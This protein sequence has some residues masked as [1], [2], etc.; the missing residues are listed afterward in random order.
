MEIMH[1]GIDN[2][3]EYKKFIKRNNKRSFLDILNV[4]TFQ[5]ESKQVYLYVNKKVFNRYKIIAYAIIE[6]Q[7]DNQLYMDIFRYNEKYVNGNYI[8]I[9]DFYVHDL[10]RRRGIGTL[11]ASEIINIFYC[12][13][14]IILSPDGDGFN[15]WNKLGFE[16]DNISEKETWVKDGKKNGKC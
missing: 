4:I 7:L 1:F 9:S 6:E 14:G 15:F 8:Y 11:F 2:K 12:D 16:N 13:F 3:D 10:Y 5:S